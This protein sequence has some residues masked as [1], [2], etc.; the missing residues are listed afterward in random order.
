[1]LNLRKI[2]YFVTLSQHKS[3]TK[4][5][6]ELHIAQPALSKHIKELEDF[7]GVELIVRNSRPLELTEAG[8]F[9]YG[10]SKSLLAAADEAVLMTRKIG[11]INKDKSMAIAF[12]ASSLYTALP[13][14]LKRIKE[15]MQGVEI[16]LQ[17]MNT[18]AQIADLKAGR[19]DVG[20]GRL[21]L[22]DASVTSEVLYEEGLY[23]AV[24]NQ[25][26]ELINRESIRLVD[27]V[28]VPLIVFPEQPRPS[29]VDIVLRVF[30]SVGLKPNHVIP[31]RELQLALGLVAAGEG[32]CI[33][34]ASFE[35]LQRS[36]ITYI[37]LPEA[38][39]KVQIVMNTR[40]AD[41]S[42]AVQQIREIAKEVYQ[43]VS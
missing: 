5:A 12:V 31:T 24:P 33:V 10:K 32:V 34:P 42:L 20:F 39:A 38:A 43:T 28:D 13:T 40:A 3:F 18:M 23:V 8:V 41:N 4:A 1:M 22:H 19:L 35:K 30:Q 14:V 7:L 21:Q 36:D 17:E 6:E 9:F 29:F 2:K 16:H 11:G 26:Q 15:E 25:M 27:L 37:P